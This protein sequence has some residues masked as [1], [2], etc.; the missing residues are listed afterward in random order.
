MLVGL[1]AIG[2]FMAWR[3]VGASA[4]QYVTEVLSVGDII[5]TVSTTGTLNPVTTV[6]VGSYVSGTVVS[7]TCDYNTKVKAGQVC[8]K[9]DPRPYQV[10]YDQAAANLAAA[11][12]QLQKDKA[13]AVYAEQHY[14]RDIG[15]QKTS[16]IS[17]DTLENDKNALDQATAQVGI[18]AATIKQ[19]Q[20]SLDAAKVNLD[21]T[22]I[23]SPVDGTVVSRSID[24][25]QTVASSFQTPTLFQIAQDLT[26]MQ[27]DTNVSET[28]IGEIKE[29]QKATF[30]VEA[31]PDRPFDGVVK[32]VR[33]API[34]VQNI[35]TYD[36]VIG[37]DNPDFL[38]LPG[39]T[40]NTRITVGAHNQV[41]RVPVQALRFSLRDH[42]KPADAT[43]AHEPRVFV[44]RDDKPERVKVTKGLS[45]G[46]FTE[47]TGTNIQ[48]GDQVI[49]NMVKSDNGKAPPQRSPL[50]F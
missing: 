6:Q 5:R 9:I 10:V 33:Q 34:S 1:G 18:D 20:A 21:Y 29:G 31:Y 41:L 19:R 3:N 15:L 40:A 43:A 42:D 38:L 39:M 46:S 30:Y 50:R 32:Q 12:A 44:L 48:T 45:D 11:D 4:P 22:D 8:A 25:G 16:A 13:A 27:V 37:V 17:K 7:L 23:V 35:V 24:V 47:V 28:D 49:V 36:V 2:G 14:A 26:Q